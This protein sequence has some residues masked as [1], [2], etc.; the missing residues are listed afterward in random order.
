MELSKNTLNPVYKEVENDYPYWTIVYQGSEKLKERVR[1]TG[2]LRARTRETS[3]SCS[4]ERNLSEKGLRS[5]RLSVDT[6]QP[7]VRQ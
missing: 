4:T 1:R 6:A 7:I 2:L 5:E 3:V